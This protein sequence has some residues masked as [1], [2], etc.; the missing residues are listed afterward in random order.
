[1]ERKEHLDA[2]LP[3]MRFFA[4]ILGTNTE[5]VLYDVE[6]AF[7]GTDLSGIAHL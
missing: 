6:D 3:L 4:E 7:P 5:V 2:I 1:M